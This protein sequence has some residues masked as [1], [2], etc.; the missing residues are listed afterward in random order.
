MHARLGDMYE[1]DSRFAA[2]IDK[3]G[4]GLTAFLVAAIRENARRADH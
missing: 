1:A 4:E 2:N 3:F